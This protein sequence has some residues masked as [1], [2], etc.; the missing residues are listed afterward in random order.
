MMKRQL[1]ILFGAFVVI[2]SA[3]ILYY[4]ASDKDIPS[5]SRRNK[6]ATRPAGGEASPVRG[7]GDVDPVMGVVIYQYDDRNNLQAKYTAGKSEKVGDKLYLTDPKVQW[8]QS[9]GE[10]IIIQ[11]QRGIITAEEAA[12]R[13]NVRS[14]LLRDE[15][16][17]RIT[18]DRRGD[19]DPDH[20]PLEHR[21]DDAVRIY[22]D[23]EVRFDN[24]LLTIESDGG[25]SVFSKEADISG[26]SLRIAWSESPR[27]LRELR[28]ARGD[29]MVIREGQDRFTSRMSLPS[30]V[31]PVQNATTAAATAPTTVPTTAAATA[32]T[33]VPT[34]AAATAPTTVPMTATTTAPTTEPAGPAP[35]MPDTYVVTFSDNVLVTSGDRQ[36]KGADELRLVVEFKSPRRRERDEQDSRSS[37]T[38]RDD[39]APADKP[40]RTPQ[41]D[42]PTPTVPSP[43]IQPDEPPAASEAEPMIITWTGPLVVKPFRSHDKPVPDR[44]DVDVTGKTL[45]LSEG[46]SQAVCTRLQFRSP[47]GGSVLTGTP[48]EPVKLTMASGERITV[49]QVRFNSDTGV[50]YLDGA[51]QMHLPESASTGLPAMRPIEKDRGDED[52]Q[53]LTITWTKNVV[54]SLGR[55]EVKTETAVENEDFLRW[56]DFFGDVNVRQGDTQNMKADE[57][58]VKFHQPVSADEPVN[59]IASLQAVGNVNMND[60][61][62]GEYIKTRKLD[63]HMSDPQEEQ[64]YPRQ[65]VATG[66]VSAVQEGMEITDGEMLTINFARRR[67]EKDEKTGEFELAVRTATL[68]GKPA[69][70][71]QEDNIIHGDKIIFNQLQKSASVIGAGNLLFY[72]DTDISGNKVDKPRPVEITWK[73]EMDYLGKERNATITGKVNLKTAGDELKCGKM[74]VTFAESEEEEEVATTSADGEKPAAFEDFRPQKIETVTAEEKVSLESQSHDKD[75]FLLQRVQLL[76]EH[77]E[78][79]AGASV[80]TCPKAG[81]LSAEDYNPPEKKKDDRRIG[82]LADNI[83]RPSQSAFRWSESMT[84]DQ[85]SRT[86]V[87][88][89]KVRLVHRS[90]ENVVLA[91]KLNVRPWGKL[92]TG[93]KTQLDCDKMKAVFAEPEKKNAEKDAASA[94]GPAVGPLEFFDATGDVN[95]QDGP[96]QVFC[97]QILYQRDTD[98]AII[99]GSLPGEPKKNA[100][101]YYRDAKRGVLNSWVNPRLIWY[102]KTN[103]VEGKGVRVRGGR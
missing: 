94:S 84:M 49:P 29:R 38:R 43:T 55:R 78:Y 18:I 7:I 71:K 36:M 86:V 28:I 52:R 95:L 24:D 26:E 68:E 35:I 6:S 41:A 102:R 17:I 25:V 90:G 15:D 74:T 62:K 93:R 101:M 20:P 47:G 32:P 50:V 60:T 58:T 98:T 40:A 83:D 85:T 65:A 14:G 53:E 2:L 96:R 92:P 99:L 66:E 46:E 69:K 39:E 31:E 79:D 57:L 21:P 75:G 33:T 12:D 37:P 76:S 81:T 72:S 67:D 44:F 97:R 16:K 82:D 23:D 9:S 30:G 54:A 63:V 34:T 100:I 56:A 64:M 42:R 45:V 48:E 27:R 87:M 73:K 4:L 1:Q 61:K 51:G 77:V 88:S 19:S 10:T 103:R 22:V 13:W 80:L 59:R 70:V 5:P 91:E 8:Y 89:G 3:F 11:A